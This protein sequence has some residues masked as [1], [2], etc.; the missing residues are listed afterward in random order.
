M[1]E[2]NWVYVDNELPIERKLVWISEKEENGWGR[3][4]VGYV[5]DGEWTEIDM[6]DATV[7]RSASPSIWLEIDTGEEE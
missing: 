2:E 6:N 7:T 1:N 5:L 3:T 4:G